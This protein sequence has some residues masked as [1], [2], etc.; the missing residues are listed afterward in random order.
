MAES[1]PAPDR[2]SR[3]HRRAER[4]R[5]TRLGRLPGPFM[6]F[7]DRGRPQAALVWLLQW[8]LVLLVGL[9]GCRLV[10][11]QWLPRYAA[12]VVLVCAVGLQALCRR[13]NVAAEQQ[14]RG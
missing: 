11:G 13:V 4:A 12:V 14:A 5:V 3:E 6:A 7:G 9:G 10:T 1:G 2:F 8:G